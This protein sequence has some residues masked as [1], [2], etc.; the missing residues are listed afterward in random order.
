MSDSVVLVTGGSG[1][2]GQHIV[3]HL[4]ILGNDVKEIRVLDVVEYKQKLGMF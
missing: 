3:K 4:Q 1:C 2:L